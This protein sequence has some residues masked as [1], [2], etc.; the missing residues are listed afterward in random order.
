MSRLDIIMDKLDA[1]DAARMDEMDTVNNRL[2]LLERSL[3]I[4][5]P[6]LPKVLSQLA[7]DDEAALKE[8]E[9]DDA[10]D[11]SGQPSNAKR[12]ITEASS[13]VFPREVQDAEQDPAQDESENTSENETGPVVPPGELAIPVG[14]TTGAAKIL[15]WPA[16]ADM[17][18]EWMRKFKV[19][20]ID[21]LRR[22][23]RRGVIRLYGRGEGV[24]RPFGFDK[25]VM[26]DS[27]VD[28]PRPGSDCQSETTPPADSCW[29]QIGGASPAAESAQTTIY[30][31]DHQTTGVVDS[32]GLPDLDEGTI[33]RLTAV[34]MLHLNIMHPI[35]TPN[36]L[37]GLIGNFLKQI[38][39][40][41][42][43]Q[44]TKVFASFTSSEAPGSKRKRSPTMAEAEHPYAQNLKPGRPQRSIGAA[45]VLLMLALGKIC[46]H[47]G[48][49]PDVLPDN[50]G[51]VSGSPSAFPFSP[52]SALQSP[53]MSSHS[54]SFPSP[55]LQER[56][57]RRGSTDSSGAGKYP[58]YIRNLDVIPGLA[59]FAIATDILGNHIGA[60]T[61]EFVHACLLAG[62][63]H[64]QLGRVLQSHAFIKEAGYAL[65]IILKP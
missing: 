28:P 56:Y 47:K 59:Y 43:D 52:P 51:T 5:V 29:G 16:V 37:S 14:H 55:T 25:D 62:L 10:K 15:Q 38:E 33:R 31:S 48:K 60:T 19:K 50:E 54:S 42:R 6:D 1:M 4:L 23:N 12:R 61:L 7:K 36:A 63:Y 3:T 57:L 18:G 44:P 2:K 34:Y 8:E 22:E 13:Q 49:I 41:K 24:E 9:E 64:G 20:G 65:S 58:P 17:V 27:T 46:E 35:I 53:L 39:E 30:R 21:P 26:I 11:D 40:T 32:A 45:I